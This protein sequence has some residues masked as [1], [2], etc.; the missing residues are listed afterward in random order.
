MPRR[1]RDSP[2][3]ER[4]STK[5]LPVVRWKSA[6]LGTIEESGWLKRRAG[7]VARE[8]TCVIQAAINCSPTG[9]DGN[10]RR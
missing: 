1:G 6:S 8:G 3:N 4:A 2:C 10:L 5:G 7:H 9:R